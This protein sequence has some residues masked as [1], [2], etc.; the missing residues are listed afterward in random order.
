MC[1]IL[2][3]RTTT[4]LGGEESASNKRCVMAGQKG[5]NWLRTS[6]KS[7]QVGREFQKALEVE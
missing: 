5:L 1:I 3:G 4:S 6:R 2:K 7:R